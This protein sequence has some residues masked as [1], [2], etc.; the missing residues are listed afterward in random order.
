M[1]Q[2]VCW[3]QDASAARRLP[4]LSTDRGQLFAPGPATGTTV[5]TC[6]VKA[7]PERTPTPTLSE[8]ANALG[9]AVTAPAN[10]AAL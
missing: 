4:L 7:V 5:P 2:T 3:R 10:Q 8:P 9:N 1:P 6:R